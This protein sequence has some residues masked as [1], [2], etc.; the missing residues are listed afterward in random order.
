MF[1]QM[2]IENI[3]EILSQTGWKTEKIIKILITAI[4]N[5]IESNRTEQCSVGF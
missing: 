1:F 5:K 3:Q 2:P 4:A